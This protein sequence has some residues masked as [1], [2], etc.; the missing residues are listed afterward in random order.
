[1]AVGARQ[2]AK[3]QAIVTRLV[4]IEELAAWTCCA[5]TRPVL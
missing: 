4:A 5:R 2:L 1:M 3:K